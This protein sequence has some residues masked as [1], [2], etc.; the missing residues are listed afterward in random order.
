M[1]VENLV[2]ARTDSEAATLLTTNIDERD[3][4]F[5]L[6]STS[7]VS[8]PPPLSLHVNVTL[9]LRTDL[10]FLDVC[11]SKQEGIEVFGSGH[12]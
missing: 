10:L 4:G 11:L 1:G 3:H 5:I 7:C 9:G 6:G 8:L 12:E 2:V